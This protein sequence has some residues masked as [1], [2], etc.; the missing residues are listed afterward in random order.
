MGAERGGRRCPVLFE[1]AVRD[2]ADELFLVVDDEEVVY[3]LFLDE[4]T[5][6]NQG[7]LG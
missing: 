6:L 3:L 5:R 4:V 7:C 1:V 2:N